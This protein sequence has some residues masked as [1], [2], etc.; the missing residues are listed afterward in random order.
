M[1][2][3][4]KSWRRRTGCV[5]LLASLVPTS[6]WVRSAGMADIPMFAIGHEQYMAFSCNGT[7]EWFSWKISP[8]VGPQFDLESFPL[9]DSS[10]GW[11]T[12]RLHGVRRMHQRF[13]VTYW[14][15]ALPLTLLSAI[16]ILLPV[17]QPEG[18]KSPPT[19]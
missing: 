4:F 14:S 16:L 15:V 3:S 5:L 6:L 12:L 19:D 8:S 9:S 18:T 7:V 13:T 10:F 17:K 11:K 2:A 1:S